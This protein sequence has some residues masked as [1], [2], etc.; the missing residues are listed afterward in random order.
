M[1][2]AVTAMMIKEFRELARDRRTM[3]MLIVLPVLLLVVFAYAANFTVSSFR[4]YVVGPQATALAGKLPPAFE[5]VSV[6]PASGTSQAHTVLRDG[7]AAV[8]FDTTTTPPTVWVDGADLLTAQSVLAELGRAGLPVTPKVLF[9][10]EL[11]TSW[12]MVPA[13]IGLILAFLGTIITTIGLVREREAGTLEQLA[14]M[15]FRPS[16]VI[17]G[18]IAPY[19]VLDAVD[20]VIVVVLGIVLF[21][22]PFVGSVA[23]FALGAAFFLF[24]V[25]GMGVLISTI[26][27]TQGQAIQGAILVLLPQILLSGMLFPPRRDAVGGALDRLRDA[28]ELLHR[29]GQGGDAERG[30][31][32]RCFGVGPGRGVGWDGRRHLRFSR[33]A[34]Q[35]PAGSHPQRQARCCEAGGHRRGRGCLSAAMPGV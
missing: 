7:K 4:T 2:P 12:Y 24:G 18:K 5:V 34:V 1:V 15:P 3:A 17:L 27:Q 25:L 6:Q 9:N 23:V 33:L 21:G 8:V 32:H 19:F 14:V 35:G 30:A 29:A 11:K 20:L 22:V 13:L 28:A 16:D 26:S 10:P 31:I